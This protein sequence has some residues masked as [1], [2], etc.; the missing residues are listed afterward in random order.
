MDELITALID[1]NTAG[2]KCEAEEMI[3]S[4][5][6]VLQQIEDGDSLYEVLDSYNLDYDHAIDLLGLIN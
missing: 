3:D 1:N 2:D 4:M 6:Y 5:L